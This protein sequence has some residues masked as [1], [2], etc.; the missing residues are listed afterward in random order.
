MFY[1]TLQHTKPEVFKR[2]C[3]VSQETFALMVEVL[4]RSLR[5]FGRPR[6]L[7]VEDM[8]LMTLM[9]LR[10]YRSLAH[11][12]ATYGVH[13]TTALR[14]IRRIETTLLQDKRFHLP[15]KKALQASETLFE[16]VL[17]DATEC[18]CE[19]PKKNSDAITAERRS[20]TLR[21]PN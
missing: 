6:K 1:S 15:G 3:G 4:N 14:T 20:V 17:V 10:E 18:P 19:R 21:K 8:L 2:L 13:E 16:V 12:G 5:E 7:C 9:Y 11:I